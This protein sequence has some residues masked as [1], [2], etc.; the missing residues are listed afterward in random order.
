MTNGYRW[1]LDSSRTADWSIS[2]GWLGEYWTNPTEFASK[3]TSTFSIISTYVNIK[4]RYVGHYQ[5]PSEANRAGSDINIA[6]D[7]ISTFG[8]NSRIW[9]RGFFQIPMTLIEETYT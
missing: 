2:G 8:T 4:F 1:S 9:G 5:N 3:V 6:I 7:T